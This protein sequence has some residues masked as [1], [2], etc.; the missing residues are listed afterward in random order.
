MFSKKSSMLDDTAVTAA[1]DTHATTLRYIDHQ[2]NAKQA[3]L[4]AIIAEQTGHISALH[5]HKEK[6]LRRHQLLT[7]L[8]S[9]F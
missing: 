1:I 9:T 5:D 2:I 7:E 3:E 6:V 8:K 4:D